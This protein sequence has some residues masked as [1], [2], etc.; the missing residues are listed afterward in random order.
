MSGNRNVNLSYTPSPTAAAF[1]QSEA[2]VRGIMG[3]LGSGKSVA[4]CWEI[5]RM[6]QEQAKG[7]DGLRR[8]KWLVVRNTLP[9]LKTTTMRTWFDWF[10]A[11]TDTELLF[12][13]R[14]YTPPFE[15]RVEFGDVRIEV[16]FLALDDVADE[17]KLKSFEVT[18]IWFNEVKYIPFELVAAG[19]SRVGRYP[20]ATMGGCTRRAI[21]MDT[22]PPDSN[23]WYHDMDVNNGWRRDPRTGVLHPIENYAPS[24]RWEFF[25]QP[26]GLSPDADNLEW[27]LQTSETIKLP[28]EERRKVGQKYYTGMMPGQTEEWINVNVHG[29]YGFIS[30]G[31]PVFKN[32]WDDTV[33]FTSENIRVPD[34]GELTIGL[35]CSGRNPSAVWLQKRPGQLQAVHELVAEGVGATQFAAMLR[36]E[37]SRLFPRNSFTVWGDPAGGFKSQTNEQT[38]FDVLRTQG[39]HVRPATEGLRVAPRVES[40]KT[41]LLDRVD[42]KP[43]LLV[44]PNCPTL[45][46]AFN[47]G[48]VYKKVG[49]SAG[50]AVY[51]PEP[52]K[53][54]SGRHADVMD[55]LMYGVI[56][57]GGARRMKRGS[58][59]RRLTA[60]V[61]GFDNF[62]PFGETWGYSGN[63]S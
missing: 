45:R 31:L 1:H 37:C 11:N 59:D 62:N 12:G 63:E 54:T 14:T 56:G 25:Q 46:K 53:K 35:D 52:D 43:G 30:E 61:D 3:P 16:I 23:H 57:V 39:F 15:H 40:V 50:E 18:G 6:G 10:P 29:Q 28:I 7:P 49:K 32:E 17:K 24:E 51:S 36:A 48:Y 26:S 5:L 33:H 38:Y 8:T 44:G 58:F 27:L 9:E 19:I 2:L 22:N 55:G 42:N 41:L 4:C 13:P 34:E 60:T 20:S 47:G 21:I